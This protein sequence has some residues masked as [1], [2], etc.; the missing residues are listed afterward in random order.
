[1]ACA[2]LFV[3]ITGTAGTEAEHCVRAP[4][5]LE[6]WY[7]ALSLTLPA[8]LALLAGIMSHAS[9]G[10]AWW[11]RRLD[12]A[13]SLSVVFFVCA[14]VAGHAAGW[15]C[16]YDTPI[17]SYTA[18]LASVGVVLSAVMFGVY[19]DAYGARE[20]GPPGD[21]TVLISVVAATS[22]ASNMLRVAGDWGPQDIEATLRSF[23]AVAAVATAVAA[24]AFTTEYRKNPGQSMRWAWTLSA[25]LIA[26]GVIAR[27]A[28]GPDDWED[29]SGG[30]TYLYVVQTLWTGMTMAAAMLAVVLTKLSTES[31]RLWI[32]SML[33]LAIFVA[34]S[35]DFSG[36]WECFT[37]PDRCADSP[38]PMETIYRLTESGT[39]RPWISATTHISFW[40]VTAAVAVAMLGKAMAARIRA[41]RAA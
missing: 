37:S 22:F 35:D 30:D 33:M 29:G 40:N 15:W 4:P 7:V 34:F 2:T 24:T 41:G 20:Q 36:E 28:L 13:P 32:G 3:V 19:R 9:R 1:M 11:Q 23:A 18:T 38:G 25:I 8:P 31:R 14:F 27:I 6:A 16:V 39:M 26:A 21:P 17:L 12:T 5:N 10:R